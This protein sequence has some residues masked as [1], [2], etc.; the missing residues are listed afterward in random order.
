M[1]AVEKYRKDNPTLVANVYFSGAMSDALSSH[2]AQDHLLD[3]VRSSIG[4]GAVQANYDGSDEPTYLNRPMLDFLKTKTAEDRWL[5]RLDSAKL[6]L[7]LARDPL[8]GAPQPGKSGSLQRMQE[9]FG[10]AAA[11]RGVV[12]QFPNLWGAI[13]EVGGDT[14]MANLLRQSDPGAIMEGLDDANL[15]HTSFEMYRPW[16][17]AFSKMLSPSTNTSPEVFWQD[18]ALR[19]SETSLPDWRI[20][21]AEGG[22]EKIKKA[23]AGLDRSRVRIVRMEIGGELSYLKP[24]A[25]PYVKLI[26]PIAWAYKNPG[27]PLYPDRFRYSAAEVE[28]NYARQEEALR[29]LV[30]EFMPANPGSRFVSAADLKSLE[31]PGWGY[32]LPFASLRQSLEDVLKKWDATPA[33]PAY[34][35]VGDRYLSMAEMFEVFADA[36][37]QRS[38]SGKFPASIR[39]GRVF[40]PIS[41]AQPKIPV[42]GEVTAEA[43]AR[44]C[45]TMVDALHDDTWSAIPKNAIPSPIPIDG[46]TITSAQFLRLMADALMAPTPDTKLR[47]R[48]AEMFPG[49]VVTYNSRRVHT[50]LGAAWT[51]KPAVL[52]NVA[53]TPVLEPAT[54]ADRPGGAR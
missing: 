4:R 33:P 34:L 2:N 9:V 15:G 21:Q 41:T 32:D 38:R 24:P 12:L 22:A 28:A 44:V 18:N 13:D 6:V 43:V 52:T 46:L 14:E 19:L 40:G 29:Y 37:G 53:D 27:N 54:T 5:A 36:L 1:A 3:F 16:A 35:K 45:A 51:Y 39:V 7:S 10:P 50:D 30:S 31:K 11:V 17:S 49:K 42:E 47:I 20:F 26:M 8:T 48:H 23:L 25:P